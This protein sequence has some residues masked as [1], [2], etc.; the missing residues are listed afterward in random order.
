MIYGYY[1]YIK[2]INNN[3][4]I[5]DIKDINTNIITIIQYNR[6]DR[7]IEVIKVSLNHWL[8]LELNVLLISL[9]LLSSTSSAL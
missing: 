6:I 3:N 7:K 1:Q 4:N 2:Y 8:L 9:L 5:K